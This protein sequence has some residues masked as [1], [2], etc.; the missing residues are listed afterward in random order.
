MRYYT[1]LGTFRTAAPEQIK[2]A[3]MAQARIYHPDHNPNDP[4]KAAK[5]SDINVAYNVLK[6]PAYRKQYDRQQ[7]L[8]NDECP[9]CLGKGCTSK[10]VGFTKKVAKKCKAC[11]GSGFTKGE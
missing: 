9:V 8:M 10:Q 11:E 2:A 5:M 3:W 6:N 7:D 4:E 1:L